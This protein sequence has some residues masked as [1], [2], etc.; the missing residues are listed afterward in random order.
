MIDWRLV[1][2]RRLVDLFLASPNRP[3]ATD[4]TWSVPADGDLELTAPQRS[5]DT[6]APAFSTIRFTRTPN[7]HRKSLVREGAFCAIAPGRHRAI[8][9]TSPDCL[10]RPRRPSSPNPKIEYATTFVTEDTLVIEGITQPRTFRARMRT[11]AKLRAMKFRGRRVTLR[12]RRDSSRTL[13][14]ISMV[15]KSLVSLTHAN[16]TVS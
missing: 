6:P 10:P 8:R 14:S 12:W 2:H 15:P 4:R 1:N 7:R 3:F 16:P 9:S 13:H 11:S 5:L